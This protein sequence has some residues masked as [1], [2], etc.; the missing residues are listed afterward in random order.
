MRYVHILRKLHWP[1]LTLDRL[2]KLEFEWS[3]DRPFPP[4]PDFTGPEIHVQQ[5]RP[6][7]G[8]PASRPAPLPAAPR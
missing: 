6:A 5:T 2:T 1:L 3:E 4:D 7:A 8:E